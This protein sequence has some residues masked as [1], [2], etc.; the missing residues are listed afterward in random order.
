MVT[1]ARIRALVAAMRAREA[2][3]L[4]GRTAN[5]NR[6][7]TMVSIGLAVSAVLIT[8]LGAVA[9]RTAY[10]RVAEATESQQALADINRRLMSEAREREAAEGQLRQMQKIDR[11]STRLN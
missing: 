4:K 7:S 6:L 11:K 3:L 9:L 1:M 2:Q 5:D 10:R 8:L